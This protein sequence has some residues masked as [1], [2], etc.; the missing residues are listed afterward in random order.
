M[1][2][3]GVTTNAAADGSTDFWAAALEVGSCIATMASIP[4]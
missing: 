4:R 1:P 2:V 3:S